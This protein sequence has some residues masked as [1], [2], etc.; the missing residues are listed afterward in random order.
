[1]AARD[2]AAASP[3]GATRIVAAATRPESP[4]RVLSIREMRAFDRRAIEQIGLPA[5]VLMENA[6]LAVAEAIGEGWPEARR[7]AVVGGPG[8]NGGDGFALA[9]QLVTRGYQVDVWSATGGREPSLEARHQLAVLAQLG[10]PVGS[11]DAGTAGDL[12]DSLAACDLIVDALFG[13]GLT[14]PLAGQW[15][16]LVAAIAAAGRPVLAVD[17]PSGLDGDLSQP[18]GPAV[19]A[20]RTVALGALKPALV[21]PPACGLAGE[22]GVADLGLPCD[23]PA[24]PGSLHLLV[25]DEVAGWLAPR[26][27]DAHKG[28]FGHVLLLAGGEGKAGAAVLAARAA[29]AAGAGLVT[30]AAPA[31]TVAALADACPEAMTLPLPVAAGGGLGAA[32]LDRLRDA[33]VAG[34]VLAVGPGLGRQAETLATVR[35]LVLEAAL[36][37]VLDADGLAAF[38]GDLEALAARRA[39]SV[40]T[41]HPGEM[42]RLLATTTAGIAADRLAAVRTAAKRSAC[43]VVLKG[44]R[45]LVAAPDGEAWVNSTGN[46]GM[47][48]GGSG[49]ALTGVV[50]ARLAQGDEAVLAACLS[51]HLHGAAGD[52]ARQRHGGPAVPAGEL[53]ACLGAAHDR[54][55]EA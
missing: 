2:G 21:L 3:R 41:P 45:T 39:P 7:V 5:L 55:I 12:A 4:L 15:A 6:A 51:V 30:V 18:I 35:Q 38:E 44:E 37:L 22:V 47:A 43:L 34:R 54:L 20:D 31:S 26:P 42:A 46:S 25:A 9:R 10:I 28:S 1:M 16:A 29:V 53:I 49:D 23:P 33:A 36:P 19:R 52:L 14:R 27:S 8:N 32:A 11:A 50:A 17:L 48:S 24:G 13:A 40:L